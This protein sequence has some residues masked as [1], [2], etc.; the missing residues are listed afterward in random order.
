V[1]FKKLA[2]LT[3]INYH[4]IVGL[5]NPGREYE[6]TRHNIGF[7]VIDGL[8]ERWG[9]QVNKYK[10]KALVGENRKPH[11]RVLLIKPQT[12]MNLS[13]NSVGSFYRFYKPP[14]DQLLLIFDDLDL[15]FGTVRIRKSGGSS[16]HKGMKSIIDQLGTEE[17]PRIRVG[18]GRPP[19]KM[20]SA[21]YILDKFRKSEK[22]DLDLILSDC[23]D[24]VETIIENGIEM[25][26]NRFNGSTFGN[27]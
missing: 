5:G 19:G 17:F 23:T 21:D 9:V 12:F 15:P 4:L 7:L 10:F 14:L 3:H 27:E 26:M 13:G 8:A 20:N 24:A 16:G 18:V 22:S 11:Q 6:L 1:I 25:A 2:E